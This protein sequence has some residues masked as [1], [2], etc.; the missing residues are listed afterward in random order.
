[1]DE[2]LFS[3]QFQRKTFHNQFKNSLVNRVMKKKCAIFRQPYEIKTQTLQHISLYTGVMHGHA[4]TYVT[5]LQRAVHFS[6]HE[7][8]KCRC[9]KQHKQTN[10]QTNKQK[11]INNNKTNFLKK[12]Q[13]VSIFYSVFRPQ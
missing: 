10:K 9:T 4:F 7:I 3:S 2:Q 11:P 1:M 13:R 5:A 8:E 6:K 12:N